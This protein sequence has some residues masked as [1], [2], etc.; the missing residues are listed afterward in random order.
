MSGRPGKRVHAGELQG[1]L[2]LFLC[3]GGHMTRALRARRRLG[4]LSGPGSD[5]GSGSGFLFLDSG[6][7]SLV[8]VAGN[9]HWTIRIKHRAPNGSAVRR[10]VL[11]STTDLP[12]ATSSSTSCV[13]AIQ[14]PDP[15]HLTLARLVARVHHVAPPSPVGHL[16]ARRCSDSNLNNP[17]PLHARGSRS[18]SHFVRCGA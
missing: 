6:A 16:S 9:G 2:S 18:R 13:G 7:R 10:P 3:A 8:G 4:G 11:S 5:A 12:P 17:C 15:A 1:F 14:E